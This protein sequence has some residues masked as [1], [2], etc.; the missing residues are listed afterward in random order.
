M[1]TSLKKNLGASHQHY[2][3]L[4]KMSMGILKMTILHIL[5]RFSKIQLDINLLVITITNRT[6]QAIRRT[7][8]PGQID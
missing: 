1:K 8:P 5:G 4:V 2:V 7:N 6:I 3:S